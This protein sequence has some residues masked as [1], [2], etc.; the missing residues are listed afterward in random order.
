MKIMKPATV[1]REFKLAAT[2]VAAKTVVTVARV[3]SSVSSSIRCP[4]KKPP[5]MADGP[6]FHAAA[7]HAAF[8]FT[9]RNA[10]VLSLL[11]VAF[12]SSRFFWSTDAQSLRPS[13]F[14]QAIKVP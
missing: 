11:S 10:I 5:A 7:V 13:M 4:K 8:W 3:L 9:W 6:T 14:A 2:R 12:S 1:M